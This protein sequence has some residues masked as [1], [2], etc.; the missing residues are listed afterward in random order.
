ME[1]ASR[2]WSIQDIAR[3][4][5]TTS[6]TLRH[7]DAVG[8]LPPSR[9]GSNGYRHYDERALVRLQRILLLRQLGLGLPAITEVLA[10]ETDEAVALAAHLAWLQSEQHRLDRQI[11]AVENTLK[12]LNG[13]NQLMAEKMFDGFDHTQYKDEVEQRWGADAY[14]RSDSWWRGM[15]AAEKAEWKERSA[16]LGRDWQQAAAAGLDPLGDAAQA[17][18]QRQFDWLR[19]IPGTPGGGAAG[20]PKL[21][22][23]GLAEMYVADERFAA[24]YGGAS[25]AAFVR[26]TMLAFAERTL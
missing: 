12:N 20:P 6:R 5:H 21:Y 15:S 10:S 17:L 13:G 9:I 14:S 22:F 18:A 26:D 24:N 11:S 23:T 7:Y 4:A 8:L 25:G 3:L 16:S 2:D 1:H 19:A